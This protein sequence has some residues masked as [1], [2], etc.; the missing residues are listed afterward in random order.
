MALFLATKKEDFHVD[1]AADPL[2]VA[3][4]FSGL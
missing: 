4:L 2:G 3:Q 1:M